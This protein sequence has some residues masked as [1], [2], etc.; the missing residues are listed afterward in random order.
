MAFG[1]DGNLYVSSNGNDRVLRYQGPSGPQPGAF[2][3]AYIPAGDGGLAEPNFLL[4]DA[5]RALYVASKR[6]NDVLRVSVSP[7]YYQE[8][9]SAGQ[10]VTFNTLT[11]GD[12]PGQPANVLDPHIELYDSSQTWVA[13]GTKLADGR[14]E[15][16][17]FTPA[18]SGTY[19]IKVSSPNLTQ[20][21][22]VLDPVQSD[23]EAET[24]STP[25]PGAADEPNVPSGFL[26]AASSL[27][28]AAALRLS[29]A[30][31]DGLFALRSDLSPA[32]IETVVPT[33]AENRQ[34]NGPAFGAIALGAIAPASSRL[35]AAPLAGSRTMATETLFAWAEDSF[36]VFGDPLALPLTVQ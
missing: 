32:P 35:T 16:I 33:S 10:A 36:G 2:I 8:T 25:S 15:S 34:S 1:P 7:D 20:G 29:E 5:S 19:Y 28:G 27:G 22:Y 30:A 31:L 26:T 9:L 23:G 14:N 11:P 21:D 4:F 13:T 24:A 3:D 6:G 12:G 17:T 18:T